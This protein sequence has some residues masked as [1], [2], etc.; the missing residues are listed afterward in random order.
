[1]SKRILIIKDLATAGQ[2]DNSADFGVTMIQG[3]EK[4]RFIK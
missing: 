1:M 2:S 4:V 3:V